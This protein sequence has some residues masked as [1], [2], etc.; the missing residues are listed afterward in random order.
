MK[1]F[2]TS[3]FIKSALLRAAEVFRALTSAW[4]DLADAT[5]ADAKIK[6]I[7]LSF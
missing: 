5:T 1:S 7:F 6:L 2:S 3:I 4:C